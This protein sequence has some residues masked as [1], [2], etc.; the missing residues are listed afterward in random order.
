MAKATPASHAVHGRRL[1]SQRQPQSPGPLERDHQ[2]QRRPGPLDDPVGD[3]ETVTQQEEGALR[4]QV[5]VGLVLQLAEVGVLVPQRQAAHHEPLDAGGQVEL[6]VERRLADALEECHRDQPHVGERHRPPRERAAPP[7]SAPA[8]PPVTV[9][10]V[11]AMMDPL[12][13]YCAARE[14]SHGTRTAHR[15]AGRRCRG[16]IDPPSTRPARLRDRVG[17]GGRRARLAH[18]G[19][20]QAAVRARPPPPAPEPG[21]WRS[22]ATRDARP[23]CSDRSPWPRVAR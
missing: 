4:E 9:A 6:R 12:D 13:R 23:S 22:A 3:S 5:A 14:C 19:P 2:E 10:S 21:C 7:A 11:G 1:G 15:V 17:P 8:A 16:V 20:G 18:Q